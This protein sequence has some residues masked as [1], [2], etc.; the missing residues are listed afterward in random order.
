MNA[1]SKMAVMVDATRIVPTLR[2]TMTP[3]PL[4]LSSIPSDATHRGTSPAK[5]SNA[6]VRQPPQHRPFKH[7]QGLLAVGRHRRRG[8]DSLVD[9]GSYKNPD[10]FRCGPGTG[11][12]YN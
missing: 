12:Y 6:T 10:V 7:K 2:L 5:N 8:N 1:T 9:N 11:V 3:S 4:S